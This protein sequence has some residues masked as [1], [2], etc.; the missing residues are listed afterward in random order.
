KVTPAGATS[1]YATGFS[2]PYALAFDVTGRLLVTDRG[3]NSV[4]RVPSG[5]GVAQPFVR[6]VVSQ[7]QGMRY[8]AQGNLY[9]LGSGQLVRLDAQD[10]RSVLSTSVS[11][12]VGLTIGADGNA[13]VAMQGSGQIAKVVPGGATSTYAT[14]LNSPFGV[15]ADNSGTLYV[16]ETGN[17]RIS[18]IDTGGQ[19][20]TITES[21][22]QSALYLQVDAD[23]Q[24][25]VLNSAS[26][27]QLTGVGKYSIWTRSIGSVASF[28]RAP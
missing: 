15:A 23:G 18:A 12:A 26:F 20:R 6:S 25:Y 24:I 28:T 2:T 5:G 14:G 3:N 10:N 4:M 21:L 1:I 19:R 27:A 22:I 13:Y 9:A 17:S 7:P 8:D 11:G 16:T